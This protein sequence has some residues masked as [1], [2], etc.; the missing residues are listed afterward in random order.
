MKLKNNVV[1][2]GIERTKYVASLNR[3]VP[4]SCNPLFCAKKVEWI[5]FTESAFLNDGAE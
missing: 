1:F 3:L 5:V 2:F 4:N